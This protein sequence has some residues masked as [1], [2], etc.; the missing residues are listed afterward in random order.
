MESIEVR[1]N[2]INLDRLQNKGENLTSHEQDKDRA[3]QHK[4]RKGTRPNIEFPSEKI[5]SDD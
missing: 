2:E 1:L 5:T 3:M 4:K